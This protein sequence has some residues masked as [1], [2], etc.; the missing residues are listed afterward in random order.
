[1]MKGNSSVMKSIF[2]TLAIDK[3]STTVRCQC[4]KS[5]Q[6]KIEKI[7]IPKE[8]PTRHNIRLFQIGGNYFL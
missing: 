2:I 4:K 7:S 1:M 6:H 3:M 8:S 5:N